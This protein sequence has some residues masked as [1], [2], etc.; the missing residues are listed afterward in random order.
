M[1]ACARDDT[2]WHCLDRLD[3]VPRLERCADEDRGA[4]AAATNKRKPNS[5][6][7]KQRVARS[8]S[9]PDT[10]GFTSTYTHRLPEYTPEQQRE[11]EPA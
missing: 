10:L 6:H 4:R 11:R 3:G 9:Q 2:Q 1:Y 7:S 5:M 8:I